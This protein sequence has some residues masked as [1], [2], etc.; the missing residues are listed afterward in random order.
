MASIRRTP[1]TA[2]WQVRYRDPTGRQRSRNF[3]KRVDAERWA[4][5]VEADKARG[6][7]V[8]PALAKTSSGDWLRQWQA[9]RL[10]LRR[11]T[12][13]RDEATLRNHIVP[14]FG[15]RPI[16]AIGPGEVRKWVAD[17]EARGYAPATIQKAH[18]LFAAAL[19][20]A[21]EDGLIVRTPTRGTIL[22][23]TEGHEMRFLAVE[24]VAALAQA[25]SPRYRCLVLTAAY[26]GLRAGELVALRRESLD[27]L[28]RSLRVDQAVSDVGGELL[29]G[30]PKTKAAR[31]TVSLP[32]FLC[33]ALAQHLA[34][35]PSESGLVFTSSEGGPIR[36]TNFRRRVWQPAVAASVGEPC[37]FHDLRHSHAALLIAQGEHPKVIQGRLGHTSIKTTLDTYGHL[38]EGL[39]EA[40]AD[41]LEEAFRS[42]DV[43]RMWAV[44]GSSARPLTQGTR[45]PLA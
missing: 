42:S 3:K 25:I 26:T 33:D 14:V 31:R 6:H 27:M 19:N 29:V 12:R 43:V 18:Q 7:W 35:Y 10:N 21:V 32:R 15:H 2:T 23:K 30:P 13:A 24:E 39:D 5:T 11:S 8:D 37:R 36:W 28:R 34:R 44:G 1:D 22:P 38:F 16:G 41:R 20:A 9:S 17:M 4:A 45:K 40:A